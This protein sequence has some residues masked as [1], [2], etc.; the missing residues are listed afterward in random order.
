MQYL[1]SLC[2][3]AYELRD[4]VRVAVMNL[5]RNALTCMERDSSLEPESGE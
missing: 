1:I 3:C 2:N 4:S 5:T